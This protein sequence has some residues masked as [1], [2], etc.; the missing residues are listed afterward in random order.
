MATAPRQAPPR[1]IP[2]RSDTLGE[3]LYALRLN[4]AVYANSELTAPW[5]IEMPPMAGMM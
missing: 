1:E 2:A 4:G 5:G 3:T